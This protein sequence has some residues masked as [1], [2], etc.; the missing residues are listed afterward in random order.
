MCSPSGE[1]RQRRRTGLRRLDS[2][3]GGFA[4][5]RFESGRPGRLYRTVAGTADRDCDNEF[6]GWSE[7]DVIDV[8]TATSN[9]DAD[10]PV[11][12]GQVARVIDVHGV[13]IEP[14]CD[15]LPVW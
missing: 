5:W 3:S 15:V 6:A 8:V 13:V 9:V 10:C 12:R 7:L 14:R 4:R 2:S 1:N 11:D